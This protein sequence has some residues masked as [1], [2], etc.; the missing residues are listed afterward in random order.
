[1]VLKLVNNLGNEQE[2]VL[3]YIVFKDS[4]IGEIVLKYMDPSPIYECNLLL[5]KL[6]KCKS[7]EQF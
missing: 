1:M 3:L 6:S 2:E 4:I 5:E 7:E